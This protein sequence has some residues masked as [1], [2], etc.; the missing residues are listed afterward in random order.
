MGLKRSWVHVVGG[1]SMSH[2]KVLGEEG[3]QVPVLVSTR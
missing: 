1:L 3:S 2:P